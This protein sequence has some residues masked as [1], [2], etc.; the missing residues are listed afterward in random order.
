MWAGS[1]DL[2]VI[3]LDVPILIAV[4]QSESAL[5]N[6]SDHKRGRMVRDRGLL[7]GDNDEAYS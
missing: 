2:L 7:E 1:Y 4:G 6:A 5:P 3:K